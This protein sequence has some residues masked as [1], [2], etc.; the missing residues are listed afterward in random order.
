M[1]RHNIII[2][3]DKGRLLQNRGPIQ[4]LSAG[5]FWEVILWRHRV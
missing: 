4:D 2:N 3:V 5:P 1:K